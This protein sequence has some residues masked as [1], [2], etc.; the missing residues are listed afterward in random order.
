MEKG[1]ACSVCNILDIENTFDA[2]LDVSFNITANTLEKPS[3]SSK[4]LSSL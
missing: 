4:L 1:F 2:L 3:D